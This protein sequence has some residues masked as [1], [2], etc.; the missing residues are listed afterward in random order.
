MLDKEGR[1][2]EMPPIEWGE[3]LVAYLFEFGP[4]VAAG[5]GSAPVSAG[6]IE[7]WS[8]LLGIEL[9]GWEARLLLRLSR[10]YLAE[11]SNATKQDCLAPWQPETYQPDKALAAIEQRNAFRN[12]AKL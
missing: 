5:M 8:R 3:Y 2:I 6:E 12:L 9:G 4:T 11:A 10:E 1:E 7:S